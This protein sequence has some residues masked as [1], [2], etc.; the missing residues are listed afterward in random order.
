M[1]FS[2]IG[3]CTCVPVSQENVTLLA[4]KVFSG[5]PPYKIY[6]C[7]GS[8]ITDSGGNVLYHLPWP[9]IIWNTLPEF[10]LPGCTEATGYS[11]YMR[12][13]YLRE[14]ITVIYEVNDYDGTPISNTTYHWNADYNR[15]TNEIAIDKNLELLGNYWFL[16]FAGMVSASANT[17]SITYSTET[18]FQVVISVVVEGIAIERVTTTCSLTVPYTLDTFRIDCWNL[19]NDVS[20]A[21]MLVPYADGVRGWDV[22]YNSIGT[23]IK[24]T[25]TNAGVEQIVNAPL[26]FFRYPT[27]DDGTSNAEITRA[28]LNDRNHQFGGFKIIKPIGAISPGG[29]DICDL[30][31]PP[32]G[33]CYI[34]L[35]PSTNYRH[36]TKPF[37]FC[38]SPATATETCANIIT[39]T[40]GYLGMEMSVEGQERFE[41][42]TC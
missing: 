30:V 3:D 11:R 39:D 28:N 36:Y 16:P 15:W 7:D 41:V 17:I 32:G 40:S 12:D 37:Y 38:Q 27:S 34:N 9:G 5:L 20:L 25:S 14:E 18:T 24:S 6:T 1:R 23:I 10:E 21:A 4:H 2:S 26:I 33:T 42:G 35:L 22:Y 8:Q 31:I 13:H 19:Y 29:Q